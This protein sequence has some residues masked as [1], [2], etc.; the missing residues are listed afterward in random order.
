M[1][2]SSVSTSSLRGTRG[3]LLVMILLIGVFSTVEAY[4]GGKLPIR[5]ELVAAYP[6]PPLVRGWGGIFADSSALQANLDIIK[7][8]GYNGFR[9]MIYN[10]DLGRTPSISSIVNAVNVAKANGL[11]IIL[12][13]HAYTDS[14]DTDPLWDQVVAA[15]KDLYDQIIWQ[16]QN[17]PAYSMSTLTTMYQNWINKVRATGDTHWIVVSIDY[18][19]FGAPGDSGFLSQFPQVTDPLNK[20]FYDFHDYYFYQYH[21]AWSVSDAQAYADQVPVAVN[22][23]ISAYG[24]PVLITETGADASGGGG[25]PPDTVV[26]GSAGYAPESLAYVSRE[27][28]DLDAIKTGYMLWTA[29]DWTGTQGA[30][31]TGALNIWGQY[32]P[33]PASSLS[34]PLTGSFNYSPSS[35][36]PN[37]TVTFIAT[38]YN[39]TS[40]YTYKW[41]FG[42]GT[43]GTGQQMT[44]RFSTL[45]TYNVTLTA[46]DAA[47]GQFT[48]SQSIAVIQPPPSSGW[49]D[50]VYQNT[51]LFT[52]GTVALIAALALTVWARRKRRKDLGR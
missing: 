39:G 50:I 49:I 6:T 33:L 5:L 7:G 30:G 4:T 8:R 16:P 51:A 12:D 44:H 15:V 19:G 1:A 27:V 20:I 21:P 25:W 52:L 2:V 32:L 23:L 26:A 3:W 35:V 45:G 18:Q 40:P 42:D 38:A 46:T 24:R 43:T 37:T 48:T 11:W 36:F 28:S 29:D 13:R 9:C 31:A 47:Q 22:S 41:A 10:S 17:E 14:F 34:P